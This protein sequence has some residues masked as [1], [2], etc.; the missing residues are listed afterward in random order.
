VCA[1]FVYKNPAVYFYSAAS[2][3][4]R[5]VMR[6][7]FTPAL[8]AITALKDLDPISKNWKHSVS[9]LHSD[10]SPKFLTRAVGEGARLAGTTQLARNAKAKDAG[11]LLRTL[12]TELN[13]PRRS[14]GLGKP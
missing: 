2:R 12:L 1:I 4:F 11:E 5:G 13:R 10:I 8:T 14:S 7:I 9:E 3:R 6:S